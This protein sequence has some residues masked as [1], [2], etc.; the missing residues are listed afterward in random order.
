MSGVNR[1]IAG[2]GLIGQLRV[3]LSGF[4]QEIEFFNGCGSGKLVKVFDLVFQHRGGGVLSALVFLVLLD[5][6]AVALL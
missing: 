2:N 3:E 5:D 4:Q 1:Q 6:L